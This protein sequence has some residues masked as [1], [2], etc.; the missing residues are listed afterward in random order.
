VSA[1]RISWVIDEQDWMTI[2]KVDGLAFP[3]PAQG[4]DPAKSR[5]KHMQKY[6]VGTKISLETF[7]NN[8]DYN[9]IM[10]SIVPSKRN[11]VINV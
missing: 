1:G 2:V 9:S 5:L 7:C 10:W 3:A 11:F 6:K 4:E 8:T